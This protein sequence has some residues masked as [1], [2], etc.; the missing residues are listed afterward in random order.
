[1]DDI[2]SHAG[3]PHSGSTPHSGR[4]KWGTGDKYDGKDPTTFRNDILG[5]VA[6][7][8]SKGITNTTEIAKALGMSTTEYRARYSVAFNSVRSDNI[9]KANSLH[10]QNWS[11]TAIAKEMDVPESTVRG[12]LKPGMEARKDVATTVANSLKES[13]PKDGAIDIGKGAELYLGTSADKLKVATQML[14][15]QGYEIHYMYENQLGTTSGQK[16]TIKLLCAPGVNVKGEDGLYAHRERIA[17]VTKKIDDVDPGASLAMKPPVSIKSKR[18]GIVY[19]DQEWAGAK[20]V[21][22]DGVMVINPNANDLRLPN[23]KRY[24]Q[25]R[26]AVDGT[27]YLKGMAVMGNAKDFPAGVDIMFNTNKHKDTPK[28]DV[29]KKMQIDKETGQVDMNNPFKASIK[30]QPGFTDPK[31]GRKKQSALNIVN[32]EG[33]WNDW[34]K[35][36]ASQMLSKQ[37]PKLAKRQLG[38]NIDR[39]KLELDQI[40]SLT[41]PIVKKK[42]L[43][44]FSDGCDSDAVSLKAAAM[45]HQKTHVILPVN[46][47]KSNEI[48]A[49]NY[50]NGTPVV[51]VRYPHGGTFEMPALK[52]NNRNR[53]GAKFVG[54]NSKDAVGINAKVAEILSGADFDGDTVLV[55]PNPRGDVKT[56]KPLAGL[57]NF[58][59]KELY[60]LPKDLPKTN[61]DDPRIIKPKTKQTE[62]GKVSNLITDMTIKGASTADIERAV[63]HSMV[64]IDSEKHLLDYKQSAKDNGIDQLKRKYQGTTASGRPGG[65]STLI[66]RASSEKKVLERRARALK[67]GGPINA[68]TG[69]KMYTN[70]GKTYR[71]PKYSVDPK[72]GKKVLSGWSEEKPRLTSTTKLAEAKDAFKLSSGTPIESVYAE[73]SNTMKGL[74]NTAR[75]AMLKEGAFKV[76]LNAKKIYAGEVSS[77]VA[78]INEAKK[79]APLERR[80]QIIANQKVRAIKEAHPEYDKED[81]KKVS[82]RE[83]KQA[84]VV[85]GITKGSQVNVTDKEWQAIQA[86]AISANRLTELLN[87]A[88]ADRIKELATPMNRP[89]MPAWSVARAKS[90]MK[91]GLTNK[92]VADALGVSVSTLTNGLEA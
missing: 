52:V 17:S 23:G 72:T 8:K 58:D 65:A 79:R 46:S 47:L 76:D 80:A 78:K 87:Y 28:L 30:L 70:T 68:R 1:M 31:T 15:D 12:W 4:Y 11:N 90:L 62:M 21:E 40:N 29:L 19:A 60:S 84:R 71:S 39:A 7:L 61:P 26:I 57:K 37:D 56:S 18:V 86:H 24:A 10:K 67:D 75:R 77:I 42:L 2:I 44:E 14:L 5:Q 66:S 33:D 38:I 9:S 48:F 35:S 91:Q 59:P 69:E 81:L 74:A 32:E 92:E 50:D 63:R 20:G 36:L 55:I 64:V 83:L 89:A 85:V 45:P 16:T 51:L 73:Y 53:E 25:V 22:R 43:Q 3:R 34:S 13:I 82:H 88:D 54:L 49:P 27:H 41:N 6:S